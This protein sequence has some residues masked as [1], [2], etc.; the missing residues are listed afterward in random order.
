[1]TQPNVERFR[2]GFEEWNRGGFE[3]ILDFLDPEIEF[4][5]LPQATQPAPRRGRE[6]VRAWIAD[7]AEIWEDQRLDVEEVIE[8]DD[9]QLIV[10]ARFA[11]RA[12]GSGIEVDQLVSN[13]FVFRNRLAV[14][15]Q[16]FSTKAG[17]LAAAQANS[18]APS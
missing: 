17:A 8:V 15:W 9:R 7:M 3:A 11:A 6:A 12:K 18:E 13:L 1:M 14:R 16:A 4:V 2:E 10:V 5:D